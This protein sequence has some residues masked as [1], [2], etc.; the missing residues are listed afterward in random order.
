[1]LDVGCGDGNNSIYLASRG[2]DVT[3]VDVSV[4]AISLAKQNAGKADVDVTFIALDA[5][6]IGTLGKK[7]DT[8]IDFA[9]FHNLEGDS[10]KRY[11]RA[12]SDV[13]VSKGQFLMMCLGDVAGEY[14]VYP[15]RF[16]P[17]P[18]SQ[19]DI[20]ASFSEGWEIEWIRMGV[21]K[22]TP[23]AGHSFA[24]LR[25]NPAGLF[26]MLPTPLLTACN[27]PVPVFAC[28]AI[29]AFSPDCRT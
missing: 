4:K 8:V 25:C 14:D 18:S 23:L 12:L 11:V 24:F 27:I 22:W 13:C 20:R 10:R 29:D 17:Q 6:D 21:V 15:H 5:L 1:V 3:G 28:Q 16:G 9:L 19:D 2:F 26:I 7:F